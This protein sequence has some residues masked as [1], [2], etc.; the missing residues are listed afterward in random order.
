MGGIVG[1][2]E[3]KKGEEKE[4]SLFTVFVTYTLNS[5][6]NNIAIRRATAYK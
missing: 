1:K 4:L 2:E 6:R 5:R 3:K